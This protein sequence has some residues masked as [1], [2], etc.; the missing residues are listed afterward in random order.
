MGREG[1]ARGRGGGREVG[2]E[3]GWGWGWG[4]KKLR[5]RWLFFLFTNIASFCIFFSTNI[6]G[7]TQNF[8][9]KMIFP[10]K[11]FDPLPACT[12]ARSHAHM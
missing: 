2:R 1:G 9:K 8:F 7:T 5:D 6:F 3:G 4:R 11:L 10:V 12:H